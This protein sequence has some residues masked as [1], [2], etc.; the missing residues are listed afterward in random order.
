MSTIMLFLAATV[1]VNFDSEVRPL[2]PELH[3][4]G[5]GPRITSCKADAIETLKSMGF[6]AART[7]DWALVNKAERVC[8]YCHMFPLM[9][10]DAN[11]PKNY[12]TADLVEGSRFAR[13]MGETRVMINSYHTMRSV[14]M[15][16]GLKVTA[17]SSDG[18]VEAFEHETLPIMAF[19]F[20]PE[21]MT[22]DPRFVE[23]MRVALSDLKENSK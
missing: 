20:H 16:E 9:H 17:R 6:K 13:I 18:V 11:D 4:S 22:E 3:S 23:L 15:A 5:F 12:H 19:Q 1:A 8:D 10:L 14:K 21:R 7:H 2:R